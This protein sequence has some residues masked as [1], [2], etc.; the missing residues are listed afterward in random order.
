MTKTRALPR[1]VA[2]LALCAVSLG[3]CGPSIDPA[4]KADIDGRLAALQAGGAAIPAPATFEPM[5][6]AAG[7]WTQYR[8]VDDQ[9][10][11]SFLTYK[12]LGEEGGA[13]W[14]ETLHETYFGRTAQ[15]LL[16]AFGS[17]FDPNQME[18]RQI[19]TLD[20]RGNVNAMP[21]AMMSMLQSMYKGVLAALVINWQGMPQET[22]TVPA[23]RFDGCY[24][25]R[26]EGQWGPWKSVAD[27][28]RHPAVPVSGLV[29]SQGLDHPF[30]MDLVAFG[31]TGATA[32]F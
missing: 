3:A 16:I 7:Q 1:G 25:A 12:V 5:P 11:P 4:A 17:R 28:W 8:M 15:K 18:I 32:D 27:S 14:L 29:R 24:R 10:R 20:R 21:P 13:Y 2:A 9:G 31:M 22:A 23:G 26:T 19:I 30:T 6:L